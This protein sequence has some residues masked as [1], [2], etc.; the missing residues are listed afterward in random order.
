MSNKVAESTVKLMNLQSLVSDNNIA[1]SGTGNPFWIVDLDNLYEFDCLIDKSRKDNIYLKPIM[2]GVMNED[3]TE[4][5]GF[6]I[7]LGSH[8]DAIQTLED[9][10]SE[11][12][13]VRVAVR[14]VNPSIT[15]EDL[16]RVSTLYG[17]QAITAYVQAK[18]NK[19]QTTVLVSYN[20]L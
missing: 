7:S 2:T 3:G 5:K 19:K 8:F 15:Q 12:I 1:E 6:A 4:R 9:N 10:V 16:D 18:A 11:T 20:E 14:S 13:K 17:E